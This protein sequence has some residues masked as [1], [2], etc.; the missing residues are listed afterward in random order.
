MRI[1]YKISHYRYSIY[2]MRQ[3]TRLSYNRNFSVNMKRLEQQAG[4]RVAVFSSLH[5]T[6][7]FWAS[8]HWVDVFDNEHSLFAF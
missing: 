7:A 1:C 4:L 6:W 8:S 2:L 3:I 5:A